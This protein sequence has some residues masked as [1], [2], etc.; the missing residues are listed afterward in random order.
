MLG[1][2]KTKRSNDTYL[3]REDAD[4]YGPYFFNEITNGISITRAAYYLSRSPA[5][6]CK[7][8]KALIAQGKLDRNSFYS[9]YGFGQIYWPEFIIIE[10]SVKQAQARRRITSMANLAKRWTK[11]ET[12]HE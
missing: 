9:S 8:V 1:F 12:K 6:L 3:N 4:R 7:H 11:P 2:N 10:D 5:A